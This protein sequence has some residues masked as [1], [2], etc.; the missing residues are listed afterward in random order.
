MLGKTLS[1]AEGLSAWE[2]DRTRKMEG[3]GVGHEF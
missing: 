1:Y 3:D 2:E